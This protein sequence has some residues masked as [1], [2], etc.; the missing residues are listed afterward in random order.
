M[1]KLAKIVLKIGKKEIE[2][3]KE[4][5]FEL[6]KVVN[7]F[8]P[9]T[10]YPYYSYWSTITYTTPKIT[11][12]LKVDGKYRMPWESNNNHTGNGIV[13]TPVDGTVT[14]TNN[15]PGYVNAVDGVSQ[16]F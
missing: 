7:E 11:D 16:Q 12:T 9:V 13:I 8:F 2:L 4:E 5:F 10:Y 14:L 15:V 6:K 1:V 3:T